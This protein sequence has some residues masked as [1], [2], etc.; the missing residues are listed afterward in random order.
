MSGDSGDSG[1]LGFLNTD[2]SDSGGLTGFINTTDSDSDYTIVDVANPVNW[3]RLSKAIAASGVV[4]VSL[5]FQQ[6]I[7]NIGSGLQSVLNWATGWIG[8]VDQLGTG[9]WT[10]RGFIGTLF[11]PAIRAYRNDLWQPS[12]EQFGIFGLFFVLAATLAM[13]YIVVR[14]LQEAGKQL[15]GNS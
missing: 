5:G 14:G 2:D 9:Q 4:T 10:G 15:A 13:L 6:V 1:P 7:A 8:Y 3:S 12:I 11:L